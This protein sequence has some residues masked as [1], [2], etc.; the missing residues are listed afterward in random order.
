MRQHHD[1]EYPEQHTANYCGAQAIK[2]PHALSPRLPY[3]IPNNDDDNVFW[4]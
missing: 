3:Q 4:Y 1:Y 2:L